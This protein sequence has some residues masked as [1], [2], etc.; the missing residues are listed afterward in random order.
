MHALRGDQQQTL[1]VVVVGAGFSGLYMLHRLIGQNKTVRLVEAAPTVGGTW[2]WNC[3]PGAR[4]DIESMDY[5]YSFSPELRHDW[6]WSERYPKQA[7]I[8]A[9]LEHVADRLD[10]RRHI[11][12][13]TRVTRAAFQAKTASWR[14]ETDRGNVLEARI[15]IMAT[16]ALSAWRQPQIT[17]LDTFAGRV[18]HTA[19][20]PAERV[21]FTERRVAVVG[22]GSS[23]IQCIPAIAAEA[24]KLY[25]LQRTANFSLP[26][27]N[28]PLQP[29]ERKAFEQ[30]A[31]DRLRRSRNSPGGIVFDTVPRP[32]RELE[33]AAL[34]AE[35]HRLWNIGGIGFLA[36][37]SDL[38]TDETANESAAQ[39]VRARIAEIVRNP[40][41]A[42]ALSPHDHPI[43]TKRICVYTE[44]FAT[45]KRPNVSLVD[46][47]KR[48]LMGVGPR[49]LTFGRESVDYEV[50]I[51]DIVFATGFDA[52]T[53]ALTRIDIVGARGIRLRDKWRS[54]PRTY[55]GLMT[56]GFPNLFMVTGPQSP[57]VLSNMVVSIEQHVEW[58][59]DCIA[60]LD[61]R[62]A[63]SVEATPE[64]EE[65]WT[66][67]VDAM[68]HQTL[69]PRA[70]SW[71]MGAN[72][73][74]KQHTFLPFVG[75]V[76]DYRRIC[77][78]IVAADYRGFIFANTV[79]RN[80]H[81]SWTASL[82]PV[83]R[84]QGIHPARGDRAKAHK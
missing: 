54:G 9:Y 71:Y 19:R 53:G 59:A 37:F 21:D 29:S 74:G 50:Q 55:L 42:A 35:Y 25:V 51:D 18:F 28:R 1:D 62:G 57:S 31:E 45:F 44:Y 83:G 7:E 76:G 34:D 16:G 38:L 15:C 66:R 39:F 63:C 49:S 23:G 64:A 13:A 75:G 32:V 81:A 46:L 79:P 80:P 33:P 20:W 58:I 84:A 2:Y 56:A 10:L 14:L 24:Q 12:F 78:E 61:Q 52:L 30:G 17:G 41:V 3:Y 65:A 8:L 4:C 40:E 6:Q 26:A 77:D 22:T 68:A 82:H 27:R 73:P 60:H 72:I 70:K 43:G 48:P 67:Q 47:R 11:Q 5:S 69:Y 36:A